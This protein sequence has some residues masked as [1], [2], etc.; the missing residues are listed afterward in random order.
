MFDAL[1]SSLPFFY[2][3]VLGAVGGA[4]GMYWFAQR[5]A[6][7][8]A[9]LIDEIASDI[10]RLASLDKNEDAA[11]LAARQAREAKKLEEAREAFDKL[12]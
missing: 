7:E 11:E 8:R 10:K 5:R 6:T 4:G 12:A 9:R 2:A 3:V 1:F